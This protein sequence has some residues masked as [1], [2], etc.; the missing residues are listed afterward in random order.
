MYFWYMVAAD[1]QNSD[2]QVTPE[3]VNIGA[4]FV[5]FPGVTVFVNC[6]PS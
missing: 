2:Y 4:N 1:L 3:L 5:S 6:V